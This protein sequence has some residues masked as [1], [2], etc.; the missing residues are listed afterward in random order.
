MYMLIDFDTK[1]GRLVSRQAFDESDASRV[2]KARLD[3]EISLLASGEMREVVILHAIDEAQMRRTHRRYFEVSDDLWAPNAG[4][5]Y[6][7]DLNAL[8]RTGS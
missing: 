5:C 7:S 2:R 1:K 8:A 4:K 3:L 6:E